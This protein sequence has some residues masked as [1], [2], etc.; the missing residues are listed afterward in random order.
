MS[1]Y[2]TTVAGKVNY[3]MTE[4]LNGMHA[5]IDEFKDY[6][7][8]KYNLVH[9]S[10]GPF[11]RIDDLA[12]EAKAISNELEQTDGIDDDT[13]QFVD[14][15][16]KLFD[17]I[18]KEFDTVQECNQKTQYMEGEVKTDLRDELQEFK[19]YI[20]DLFLTFRCPYSYTDA[21]FAKRDPGVLN[22]KGPNTAAPESKKKLKKK[23]T[24][25]DPYIVGGEDD[26]TVDLFQDFEIVEGRSFKGHSSPIRDITKVG[27]TQFATCDE[28]GM[29]VIWSKIKNVQKSV[30]A[31]GSGGQQEGTNCHTTGGKKGEWLV[32]GC[33]S[34]SVHFLNLSNSRR[35]MVENFCEED[36]TGLTCL[37]RFSGIIFAVQDAGYDLSFF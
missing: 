31:I 18:D 32:S 6:C 29:M 23:K 20:E 12:E 34:G 5:I 4:Y 26:I 3:V 14:Q 2:S 1:R 36:I 11:S 21:E 17:E 7:N 9:D 8:K 35:K 37:K 25:K 30:T 13:M 28:N 15:S 10:F 22:K 24:F 16:K 27:N 33:T 19:D